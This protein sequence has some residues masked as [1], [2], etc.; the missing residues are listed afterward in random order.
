MR[1]HWESAMVALFASQLKDSEL[2]E[3]QSEAEEGL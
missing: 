1:T 2:A 3:E